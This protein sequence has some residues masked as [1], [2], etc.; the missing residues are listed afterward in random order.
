MQV[1][2][3]RQD[4]LEQAKVRASAAANFT[5]AEF[6]E[7]CAELLGE[8]EEIAEKLDEFRTTETQFE[9]LFAAATSGRP[10]A[11]K[12]AVTIETGLVPTGNSKLGPKVPP[13]RFKRSE[14]AL[15][16]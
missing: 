4:L 3:Y 10:S 7:L 14:I 2:E 6:V 1:M 12:S 8:A 5:H 15:S 16:P 13:L 9:P 11:L